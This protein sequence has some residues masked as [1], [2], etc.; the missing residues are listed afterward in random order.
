MPYSEE[1][2]LSSKAFASVQKSFTEESEKAFKFLITD[3]GFAGPERTD[4]V[5]KEV[6]YARSDMRCRVALDHSEMSIM[7]DVE[8]EHGDTLMIARLD[9]LV[10]AARISSGNKVARNVHTVKNLEKVLTEQAKFLRVLLPY[11]EQETVSDLMEC[12]RARQWHIR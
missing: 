3:F 5:L 10:S 12:S 8:V 6:S 11:L 2:V 9:N 4:E 1:V 7:T